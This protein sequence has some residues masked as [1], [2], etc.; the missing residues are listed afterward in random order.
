MRFQAS[1]SANITFP[2]SPSQSIL[3]QTVLAS[4]RTFAGSGGNLGYLFA[5]CSSTATD[6]MRYVVDEVNA[7]MVF[8]GD[9]TGVAASPGRNASIAS[10]D[11]FLNYNTV[12]ATW[13]GEIGA[14]SFVHYISAQN[15]PLQVSSM[16]GASAGSG[17]IKNTGQVMTIGNRPGGARA[18]NGDLYFIA[19]W[20]RVL[21]HAEL[22]TAQMSG[23]LTVPEGL[24][25]FF[26]NMW[27]WGPFSYVPS[28]ITG[29]SLAP[30]ASVNGS[31]GPPPI[32]QYSRVITTAAAAT[33]NPWHH[34]RQL[35][36]G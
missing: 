19:R 2:N 4:F 25:L 31:F 24:V 15:A 30:E 36:A 1:L 9:S 17:S 10:I 28:V 35:R 5:T 29:V 26:A 20:D 21:S 33:G 3:A 7:R 27:D 32:F 13:E 22:I 6:G 8:A 14:T 34:Y 23:P 18:F 11:S 16:E 12:A